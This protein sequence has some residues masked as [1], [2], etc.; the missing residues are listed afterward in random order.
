MKTGVSFLT[1]GLKTKGFAIKKL[2]A[3]ISK[4]KGNIMELYQ[5]VLNPLTDS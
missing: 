2:K 1:I 5:N 3:Q 4:N